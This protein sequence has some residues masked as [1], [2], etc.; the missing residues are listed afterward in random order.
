MP[1]PILFMAI[2]RKF[3]EN[4]ANNLRK[5]CSIPRSRMCPQLSNKSV[6]FMFGTSISETAVSKIAFKKRNSKFIKFEVLRKTTSKIVWYLFHD[7]GY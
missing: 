5:T 3:A 4:K 7:Y 2:L 1:F 6:F